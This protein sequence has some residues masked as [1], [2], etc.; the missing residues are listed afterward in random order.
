MP[1]Q[2]RQDTGNRLKSQLHLEAE[3]PTVV[4]IERIP[5]RVIRG[6][7]LDFQ[8]MADE[9]FRDGDCSLVVV[10]I[11]DDGLHLFGR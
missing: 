4:G 8:A 1:G 6:I 2:A 7:G 3:L 5:L 9:V 10:L 11:A